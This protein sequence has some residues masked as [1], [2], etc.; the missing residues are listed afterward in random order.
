MLNFHVVAL[1]SLENSK[2]NFIP[3]IILM[4]KIASAIWM[5]NF[6]R[7]FFPTSL[8]SWKRLSSSIRFINRAREFYGKVEISFSSWRIKPF[9]YMF[10]FKARNWFISQQDFSYRAH[11]SKAWG[12]SQ[13]KIYIDFKKRDISFIYKMKNFDFSSWS[14]DFYFHSWPFRLLSEGWGDKIFMLEIRYLELIKEEKLWLLTFTRFTPIAS[15]KL[16]EPKNGMFEM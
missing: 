12:I 4:G 14:L 1:A 2:L 15:K 8:E 6:M 9:C 10:N 7:K 3:R 5:E 16:N 11:T 13:R